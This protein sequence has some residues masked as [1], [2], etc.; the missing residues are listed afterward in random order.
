[1]STESTDTEPPES[2]GAVRRELCVATPMYGGL[3]TG[4]FL[5]STLELANVLREAD[6]AFRP[7]VLLGDSLI[8]RARNRLASMFLETSATHLLFVDADICFD[9]EC[10]P[11]MMSQG[12]DVLCGI[13]PGG[14]FNWE[15]I[16]K[17]AIAGAPASE[18]AAAGHDPCVPGAGVDQELVEVSE[19][20]TGFMMIRREV[21]ETLAR[22]AATYSAARYYGDLGSS[23]ARDVRDADLFPAGITDS[24]RYVSE[25]FGFCL[26]ARNAGFRIF[27]APRLKFGHWKSFLFRN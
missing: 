1:M 15:A 21:I 13:P 20:G 10:V 5:L 12:C 8:T 17:A 24:G 9:P 16:R 27:A 11:W 14:G 7:L 4:A 2:T 25:D 26:L 3:C 22:S 18:L 6:I 19:A 23:S